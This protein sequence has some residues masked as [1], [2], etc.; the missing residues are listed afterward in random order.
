VL[1]RTTDGAPAGGR[2]TRAAAAALAGALCA[3]PAWPG[4]REVAVGLESLYYRTT[5]T[6]LNRDDVLGL[7]RGQDL[8]RAT[9]HYKESA[10]G[11]RLVLQGFVERRLGGPEEETQWTLRQAYVQYAWGAGLSLRAGK[12]RIAWGS[13][14][15]W[16]P[17]NRVEPPR[18][19][20]N[21]NLEQESVVAG[22]MDWIPAPWA[23]VILVGARGTARAGD[24]PF[25]AP[26]DRRA[27]AAVRARFLVR[28]TDVA[29][30]FSGGK[31]QRTLVGLDLGRDLLGGRVS[32]HVEAAAYRGAELGPPR[33]G[34]LFLRLAAGLLHAGGTTAVSCEYFWNGEGYTDAELAGYLA[35][36]GDAYARASDPRL[37]AGARASALAAYLAG[38]GVPYSGGLGL[39]RHYL[40]AAWTRS[41]IRGRWTAAL[42]GVL[43][44]SDGGVALTPGLAWAPRGDVTLH[45]DAVLPLGPADAEYRLAPVRGAVQAR[46][47]VLF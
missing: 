22:R 29:L 8:L 44:L 41:E 17:T 33:D 15:A 10:G 35:G 21:T 18:N 38:V 20:L 34:R 45:L 14:F 5:A 32:A 43:G 6:A 7:D 9:L 27:T 39:R 46:A 28:D 4:E 47:R 25:A 1:A 26:E 31:G 13:G 24:L 30:V 11:A 36:L 37:P 40:H 2:V 16:N 23:G 19:P 42:R 12:Q 3:A